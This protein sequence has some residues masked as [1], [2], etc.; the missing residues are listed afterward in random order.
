[1]P[2]GVVHHLL[3]SV[4]A[5]LKGSSAPHSNINEVCTGGQARAHTLTHVYNSLYV[6]QV[7][8]CA[9]ACIHV[10]INPRARA[11]THTQ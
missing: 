11:H 8:A 5:M 6:Y 10:S 7:C 2:S 9:Y 1:M 3:P 4:P